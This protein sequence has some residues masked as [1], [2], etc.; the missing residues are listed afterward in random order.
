MFFREV[1]NV[2]KHEVIPKEPL[3]IEFAL[4]EEESESTTKQELE[5]EE[6]QTQALRIS[7]REIR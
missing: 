6:T 3:K 4:N 5:N 1:K 2:I 7:A